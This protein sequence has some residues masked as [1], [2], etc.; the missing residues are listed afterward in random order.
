VRQY[1]SGATRDEADHKPDF[2]G[3]LS[4]PVLRAF[5]RYMQKHQVQA[6]GKL[7]ASDNWKKG[8]PQED[9]LSSAWRHFLDWQEKRDVD[10][11]MALLF[12]VQGWTHEE[13]K[14]EKG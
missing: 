2:K 3:F 12:N 1:D 10:S 8:I 5:G 11:A 14:K 13:L 4:I 7:R 6:D 9:Y